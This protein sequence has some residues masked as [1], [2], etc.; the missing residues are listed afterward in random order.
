MSKTIHHLRIELVGIRPPIWRRVIVPSAMTLDMLHE[1]IQV[2]M[3]WTNDHLHEFVL[4]R[5]GGGWPQRFSPHRDPFGNPLEM[6]GDDEHEVTLAEVCPEPKSVLIYTYDFGDSWDHRITVQKVTPPDPKHPA[7]HCLAGKRS[8]PP[9][10]SGGPHPY[11]SFCAA[12]TDPDHPDHEDV[13]NWVEEQFEEGFDP[14]FIDI[15][16]I[17]RRLARFRR[18]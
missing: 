6:D 8:G 5:T 18:K 11:A 17:N 15:D 10:D 12:L 4:P 13:V 14:E 1:V 7:P 16:L 2:V 3:G 9:E